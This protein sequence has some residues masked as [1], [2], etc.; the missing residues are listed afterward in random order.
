MSEGARGR[1]YRHLSW[2]KVV[3]AVISMVELEAQRVTKRKTATTSMRSDICT[4]LREVIRIADQEAPRLFLS[5]R[6]VYQHMIDVLR[7]LNVAKF[8]CSTYCQLLC[9]ILEV[10]GYCSMIRRQNFSGA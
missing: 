7:D 10:D 5:I 4:A 6:A 8:F 1:L 2:N 9:E 3:H